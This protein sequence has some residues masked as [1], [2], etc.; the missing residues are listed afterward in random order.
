MFYSFLQTERFLFCF[1]L[2]LFL[3]LSTPVLVSLARNSYENLQH[4]IF[5][6]LVEC[7][8]GF[9]N[10]SGFVAGQDNSNGIT[11]LEKVYGENNKGLAS[12][13]YG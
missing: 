4:F 13:R 11:M 3:F 8:S 12:W 9:R 2:F 10:T 1:V 6:L 5:I 7:I